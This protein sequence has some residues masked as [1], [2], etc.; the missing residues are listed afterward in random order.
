VNAN[1]LWGWI[2]GRLAISLTRCRQLAR[3]LCLGA[4]V[5][6]AASVDD[7]L[8]NSIP[9]IRSR[10]RYHSPRS[11]RLICK[12]PSW[13]VTRSLQGR[14]VSRWGFAVSAGEGDARRSR[15]ELRPATGLASHRPWFGRRITIGR[16]GHGVGAGPKPRRAAPTETRNGTK[17]MGVAAASEIATSVNGRD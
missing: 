11:H 14:G 17:S 2:I 8:V 1:A 7:V 5:E 3:T 13:R 15:P 6:S 12:L 4:G 16:H 10:G 9:V